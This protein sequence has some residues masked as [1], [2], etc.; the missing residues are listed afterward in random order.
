MVPEPEAPIVE[1][2]SFVGRTLLERYEVRSLLAE[3]GMGRVY[4]GM[5][6][7]LRR[8]V[9][10][11]R[12]H[13][14]LR[15]V[16]GMIERFLTEARLL[17][18]LAHPNIVRVFDFGQTPPDEGADLFLVMELLDGVDLSSAL[19]TLERPPLGWTVGILLQTLA[20][21]GEAHEHGVVH[22]DVKPENILLTTTRA[23][24][25]AVKIIDFGIAKAEMGPRESRNETVGTPHFMAPE[26]ILGEEAAPSADLYAVGVILFRML[27]GKLLFDGET[28]GYILN[29]HLSP[30][31]PDPRRVAP[32]RD[33]PQEIADVCRKAIAYERADRFATADDF[34]AALRAALVAA[35]VPPVRASTSPG[36]EIRAA[37]ETMQ[38]AAVPRQ[39]SSAPVSARYTLRNKRTDFAALYELD[40]RVEAALARGDQAEVEELLVDG[41]ERARLL[42]DEQDHALAA[43]AFGSFG[44]RLAR[45]LS[46]TGRVAEA[47]ELLENALPCVHGDDDATRKLRAELSRIGRQFLGTASRGGSGRRRRED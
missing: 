16:P 30:E 26:Q 25:D 45:R 14:H 10:I 28:P 24:H 36:R 42:Y 31:R 15:V 41:V 33:I 2:D 40:R 46:D 4:V 8:R 23:G 35:S 20:A 38:L 12:I 3:G 7:A 27:T 11:K 44:V 18:Q 9:A 22:R 19:G 32:E 13:P 43:L 17:S 37:M 39:A 1:E 5:Q 6:R 47:V 34:S 21:L 29:Q